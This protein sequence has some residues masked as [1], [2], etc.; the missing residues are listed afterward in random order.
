MFNI[1]AND[2]SYPASC[3]YLKKRSVVARNAFFHNHL[4]VVNP[5]TGTTSEE[6]YVTAA[7][8]TLRG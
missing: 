7:S 3:D 1:R 6:G 2:V 4:V 5:Q 8:F